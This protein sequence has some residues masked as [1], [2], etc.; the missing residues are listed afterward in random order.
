MRQQFLSTYLK[1][2]TRATYVGI[3][4]EIKFV[5]GGTPTIYS[6]LLILSGL[7]TFVAAEKLFSVMQSITE[8]STTTSFN[9][10]DGTE[11][12]NNNNKSPVREK[13]DRNNA[14]TNNKKHVRRR[15]INFKRRFR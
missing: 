11:K 2:K 1:T 4:F 6:G 8:K 15:V 14:S 9:S 13:T 5:A 7:L 12:T 3:N 10:A